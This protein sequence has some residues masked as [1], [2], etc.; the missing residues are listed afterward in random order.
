MRVFLIVAVE[1][2]PVADLSV[3]PTS[4]ELIGFDQ[5]LIFGGN[6]VERIYRRRTLFERGENL[7][8]SYGLRSDAWVWVTHIVHSTWDVVKWILTDYA[9]S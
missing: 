7:S 2:S 4:L 5:T 8:L 3:C 1:R 6:C 9:S